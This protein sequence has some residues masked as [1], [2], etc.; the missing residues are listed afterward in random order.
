VSAS[1]KP[2]RPVPM[3]IEG[4]TPAISR[5]GDH[6]AYSRYSADQDIWRLELPTLSGRTGE[7]VKLISSAYFEQ[8]AQYSPD[9]RRI[10]FTSMRSGR[11]EIW[12]CNSGGSDAMQLTSLRA[13][14]SGSP[15]WSPNG[16]E[17][18]FDSNL[19]GQF[20]L[21]LINADGGNLRRVTDNP[22][23]DAVATFSRDGCSIYFTSDRTKDWQIWK[24][25]VDG[26]EPVQVTRGG[27][28]IGFESVDGEF[29][30]YSRDIWAT[31]IWRVSVR[32]GE[33]TKVLER[34]LGQAFGVMRSGIYF[35]DPGDR[36]SRIQFLSF[37][38]GKVTTLAMTR[39]PISWGLSVSPDERFLLYTQTDQS[40]SDLMLVENFR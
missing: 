34:V 1:G 35:V 23:N 5:R 25:P 18:V 32:G 38:T 10:V 24:M 9:G 6:L 29:V 3:N 26:G 7:P 33:E 39:L 15:S 28:R 27:G 8:S 20:E 12:V 2:S 36:E 16:Q 13:W 4:A 14:V 17:I 40:G 21:Y 31:S 30:Y 37:A 22:A 19:E 11:D